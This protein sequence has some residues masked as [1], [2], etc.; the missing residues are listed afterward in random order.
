MPRRKKRVLS[1]LFICFFVLDL[2]RHISVLLDVDRKPLADQAARVAEES[3]LKQD[4]LLAEGLHKPM[5]SHRQMK[6]P[7][8]TPAAAAGG[9]VVQDRASLSAETNQA[10][11]GGSCLRR[12]DPK[13]LLELSFIAEVRMIVFVS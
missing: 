12:S 1:I 5:S 6:P 4:A 8:S 11:R 9:V 13:S 3:Q 2:F 10:H 7:T